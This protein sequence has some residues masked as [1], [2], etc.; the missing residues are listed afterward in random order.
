MRTYLIVAAGGALGSM[1]RF[2]LSGAVASRYGET[3]PVGTLVVNVSGCFV[4]G[5]L[6]ALTGPEGRW[7][8]P[9]WFRPFAL[10]GFLGGYTTFSSFS[11]Q[12]LTLVQDGDWPGAAGNVA[13]S[14]LFCLAG[15]WLGALLGAQLNAPPGS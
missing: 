13:V 12:T 3:F 7:L 2:W 9:G 8:A 6:A 15:V 4:I 14:V 10:V 1:A 11:L 5:L